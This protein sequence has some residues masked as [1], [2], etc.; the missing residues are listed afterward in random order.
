MAAQPVFAV[1]TVFVLLILAAAAVA[2]PAGAAQSADPDNA[3]LN[4]LLGDWD[5]SGTV[6]GAAV[7]YRA[8]GERVLQDGFLRLHVF[9]PADAPKYEADIFMC[10]DPHAGAGDYV[11]HW[12]DQF[13]AAG[14]RVVATGKREGER[15]VVFFPYPGETFRNTFTR[16]AAADSWSLVIEAQAKDGT[17]SP[18][19]RYTLIR[20]SSPSTK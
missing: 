4:Q 11:V 7:K 10:F 17:W 18:F 19:A 1:R 14:G 13:G 20:A 16:D 3:Y 6:R 15:L 5:M 9:D 8:R 12:L 2:S